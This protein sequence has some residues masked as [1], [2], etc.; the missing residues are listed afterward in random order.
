MRAKRLIQSAF[1]V[2]SLTLAAL[3]SFAADQ[4]FAV[5]TGAWL[6]HPTSTLSTS[7]Q[8][9]S[10]SYSPGWSLGGVLGR[11]FDNGLRVESE[12][13]Y[14]Q[15][16]AKSSSEDQKSLS[17]LVNIWWEAKNATPVAPYFGGG[18]GFARAHVASPGLT[19]NTGGGIAYQAG[20]GIIFSQN[21]FDVDLGYRYFG[22]KD[23]TSTIGSVDLEGSLWIVGVR[24]K[25]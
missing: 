14:R 19:D 5:S 8:P 12:L 10:T 23:T 4:Y 17:L 11:S 22:I 3:P 15:A 1:L 9:I 16:E 13:V 2:V 6:P 24:K 7:L 18:F 20:G 25:F 21:A